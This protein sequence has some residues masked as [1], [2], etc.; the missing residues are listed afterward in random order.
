MDYWGWYLSSILLSTD[1][2]FEFKIR[3]QLALCIKH[4]QRVNAFFAK[5]LQPGDQGNPKLRCQRLMAPI[6]LVLSSTT[7]AS[8]FQKRPC[9]QVEPIYH[10]RAQIRQ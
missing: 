3:R 10:P 2:P 8:Y 7:A 9:S 1:Q 4:A 6:A 5:R